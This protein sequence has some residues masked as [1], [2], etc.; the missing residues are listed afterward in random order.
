MP[1]H[2]LRNIGVVEEVH[3][4]RNTFAQTNQRPWYAAVVSRGENRFSG[5][6]VSFHRADAQCDISWRVVSRHSCPCWASGKSGD[7][8]RGSREKATTR[9]S[10][11]FQ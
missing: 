4:D 9:H 8:R 6:N 11:V 2:I 1:V 7:D 5:S 3:G 10:S